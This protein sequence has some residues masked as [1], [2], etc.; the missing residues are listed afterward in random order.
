MSLV[1]G[2]FGIRVSAWARYDG[3]WINHVDPTTGDL[4]D[5]DTNY[6][7]AENFRIAALWKPGSAVTITPSMVY[8]KNYKHDEN[9]YW[10]AYSNPSNGV[11]NNATPELQPVP[12]QYALPA[13]KIDVNFEKS[14]IISNSSYYWRKE[15]SAY[16]GTAYDLAYYESLPWSTNP[17]TG[18]IAC[19]D[20]GLVPT[21]STGL[22][23]PPPVGGNPPCSWYPLIDVNGIHLPPGFDGYSTPNTITNRQRSWTQEVRWQ[24]TDDSS[25]WR[26]T[27]GAFW[28]YSKEQS[29][30]ELKDTQINQLY[31]V[32]FGEDA[33]AVYGGNWY[34]C[35]GYADPYGVA[36]TAI[37]ACDI[38]YNNNQ[39][40]DRQAAV[41]GELGYQITDKLRLTLGER[42][43]RDSFTISHYADGFENYGPGTPPITTAQQSETPN[44]PK[45]NL[46]YQMDTTDL[47]Y[48]TYAKGFREGGGNPP[49]PSYCGTPDVPGPLQQLG[50]AT[51]PGTYNPDSTQSYEIGTKNS[52]AS[53]FK[54][55][56]SVYYIQWHNIQQ[57]VY[58]AGSCGLQFTDNLGTAIAKGADIQ[59]EIA[60]GH[61]KFDIATGYTDARYSADSFSPCYY[62]PTPCGQPAGTIFKPLANVGDAISGEAATEYAPGLNAPWTA[63]L[64]GE[65]DFKAGEHPAFVRADFEFEGRNNWL[66]VLQDPA[67]AQFNPLGNSLTVSN[68]YTL[69]STFF[70]SVRGGVTL[71]S[72]QLAL[73]VDNVF[74]SHTET[75][76][77][78]SQ[79]DSYNPT[80]PADQQNAYTFRPRTFGITA[81]FHL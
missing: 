13:L 37:P 39:T 10:P 44:T 26:W 62:N 9:T 60:A 77:Q 32:L 21:G 18:G 1:D 22:G 72:W 40:S 24:S 36:Y 12:D 66:S 70:G 6:A 41:Y 55:A 17:N 78:L 5:K 76:Y 52:F 20:T 81:T 30:E 31:N 2:V 48:A 68:T 45:V 14:E 73:F 43:A 65:F 61:W 54:I 80:P 58:V 15:L 7:D 67:N 51:A 29:I 4:I 64:G 35:P 33:Y 25:R 63:S 16:E 79:P 8:Q 49:L 3:G 75:N 56:T 74:D 38:Y 27:I 19:P 50:F 11:Y 59:I 69:P 46:S 42:V 28:Q 23:Q 53:W 47:F 34:T 57:N 71:N